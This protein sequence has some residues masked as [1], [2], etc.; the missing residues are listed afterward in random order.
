[1]VD[2]V[3]ILIILRPKYCQEN[4]ENSN[5]QASKFQNFLAGVGGG[6]MNPPRK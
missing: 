1:M 6:G 4:I 3:L 5:L 2:M